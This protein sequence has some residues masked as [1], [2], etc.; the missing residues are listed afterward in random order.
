MKQVVFY[1]E[2][3]AKKA[4]HERAKAI[5]E[6]KKLIKSPSSFNRSTS[7][8][9]AGYVKNLTFLKDTGEIADANVLI[10]DENKIRDQETLDGYYVLITSEYE[11]SSSEIIEI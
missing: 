11:K 10:L 1:S 4:R 6:D 5:E 3:Y 8:G 7:H 2:K 9:V